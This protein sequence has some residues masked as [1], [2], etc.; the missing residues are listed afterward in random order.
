MGYNDIPLFITPSQAAELTGAHV[1]SIRRGIREGRIPAEKLNGRWLIC[2]D[3]LFGK[4]KE[5]LDEKQS[6]K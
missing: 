5:A 1:G 6:T 2:K 4:T 3:L